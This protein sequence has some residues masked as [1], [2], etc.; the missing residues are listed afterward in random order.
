MFA[1]LFAREGG[2]MALEPV[3]VAARWKHGGTFEPSQFSW[4]GKIYHVKSTGREWEDED[5]YHVLC[6]IAD[7]QVF[8]LIFHLKPAGWLVR[9]PNAPSMA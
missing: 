7:G 2:M 8:E 5:G 9:P 1:G 6:M 3:E 4:H